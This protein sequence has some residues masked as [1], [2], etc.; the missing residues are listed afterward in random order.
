M[1]RTLVAR[2]L[3][4]LVVGGLVLVSG[5]TAASAATVG[6]AAPP[7]PTTVLPTGSPIISSTCQATYL[8]YGSR[9]TCVVQLQFALNLYV[10][11]DLALDG[12]YGPATTAA[13]YRFQAR[14]GLAYDGRC[15]PQTWRTLVWIDDR[16]SRGLPY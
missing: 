13:V 5:G 6:G 14:Y 4:A 1:T 15:G 2:A 9:G 8:H 7:A 16:A 12:I 11:A 3:V 10:D